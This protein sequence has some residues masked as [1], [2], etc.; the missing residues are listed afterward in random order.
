[1]SDT[2]TILDRLTALHPRVI[3]LSLGRMQDL[4][5]ALDHPERQLPP[6][7]HVAGTNGKGSVIATLQTVLEAAGKTVHTYISPHLQK[8]NERIRLGGPQGGKHISDEALSHVLEVCETANCGRPI[9]FFEITTAAAFLAFSKTPADYLL[10]EVGLGGRLDATNVIDKPVLSVITPVDIDHQYFLGEGIEQI[11]FEKTG[12][13]KKGVNAVIGIQSDKARVVIE[14]QADEV[15]APL[16]SA[17]QY[18]QAYEENGRLVYQDE[19]GLIDLPL[20]RLVGRHQIDNAGIAIAA[21]R[22]LA[23][24][25]VHTSHIEQGIT[26]TR[27]PGRLELLPDGLFHKLAPEGCDIWLDGGHNPA[28]AQALATS[29]AEFEEILSRPLVLI[30]GMLNNKDARGFLQPFKG[31][32]AQII[33]IKIPEN[34]NAFEADELCQLAKEMGFAAEAAASIQDALGILKSLYPKSPRI[35]ICGSLYLAGHALDSHAG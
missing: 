34:E 2:Q 20:P 7:I 4:L 14:R 21:I 1:M 5:A 11:A 16:R 3:D 6:V 26:T 23:D 24:D 13:L 28:A 12:I 33:T 10:L 9:T 29:L 31:L 30:L 27:W 8:F 19:Q 17:G 15:G 25:D 35:V 22:T 32:A 18:W